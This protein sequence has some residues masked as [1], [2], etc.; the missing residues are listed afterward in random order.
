MPG[1][2]TEF[3]QLQETLISS[4]EG[5]E[6]SRI[7]SRKPAS[8]REF[9][10][11]SYVSTRAF[12]AEHGRIK[13]GPDLSVVSFPKATH[14]I[15]DLS[16]LEPAE[17]IKVVLHGYLHTRV[18]LTKKIFIVPLS[19][20]D[21]SFSVQVISTAQSSSGVAY[22]VHEKLKAIR[23]NSAVVLT[24]TLKSRKPPKQTTVDLSKKNV[25]VEIEVTEVECLNEW[26]SDIIMTSETIFPF[27][28]RH[29]QLRQGAALREALDFR[30]KVA[31]L[32]RDELS[33]K[34]D[35]IEI[36]TPLLFKSTPEGAQEFIVPTRRKGLAYA[37][38]QSPQQFKQILMA[39]GISRYY[40]IAK[41]F[42]DEDLRADRQPEFTQVRLPVKVE[43][44]FPEQCLLGY[45]SWI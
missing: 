40:Q 8:G 27:E 21:L 23:P 33:K 24:G 7:A 18:N 32:C 29:L 43:G 30:A 31:A 42:R 16:N 15:S 3:H 10:K 26:P 25:G 1:S 37:L 20:R 22:A 38:P 9:R 34:Y 12:V 5:V 13:H 39:G 35:F 11:I 2:Q 45:H 36:E 17:N 14:E 41:C 4:G 6:T 28:Q 19:D 44:Q